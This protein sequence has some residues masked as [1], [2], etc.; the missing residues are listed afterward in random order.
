MNK[1][2]DQLDEYRFDYIAKLMAMRPVLEGLD[3]YNTYLG[4]INHFIS[5]ALDCIDCYPA[6]KKVAMPDFLIGGAENN[7]CAEMEI[8]TKNKK[9]IEEI[10]NNLLNEYNRLNIV[11]IENV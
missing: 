2:L 10:S 5:L 1:S 7:L 9:N 8:V 11:F 4:T 6:I 3:L